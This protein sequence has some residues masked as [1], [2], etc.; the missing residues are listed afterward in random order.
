MKL[1]AQTNEFLSGWRTGLACW[2]EDEVKPEGG[3]DNSD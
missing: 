1:R 2:I 3:V